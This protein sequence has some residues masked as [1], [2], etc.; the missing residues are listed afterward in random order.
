MKLREAI[1]HALDRRAYIQGAF[2]GL[3]EPTDQY[4]PKESPWYVKLPETKRDVPRVKTLLKEAG[5]GPDFELEIMGTKSDEE[6]LQVLQQQLS[7]S[8][9]KTKVTILERGARV[10]R[11]KVGD[12]MAIMSGSGIPNDP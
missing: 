5:V 9:I 11:E 6:E 12:F 7:S 4:W 8:G 3:G 2:W 1:H 10:A